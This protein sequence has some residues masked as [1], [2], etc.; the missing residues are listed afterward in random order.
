MTVQIL[1]RWIW[2][3]KWSSLVCTVFLLVICVTGLPLVFSDEIEGL[4]SDEL[5]LSAVPA[6]TPKG[7]LDQF[8]TIARRRYPGERIVWMGFD[9]DGAPKVKVV[10][11]PSWQV[12]SAD[13]SSAHALTLDA[14]TGK[15]LQDKKPQ[16]QTGP[17]VMNVILRLH[18]D[19]FAGLPGQL[20]LGG[21]AVLFI[22]AIASG[23][24]LYAPFMRKAEFGTIRVGKGARLKYLDY[25]NLAG[26]VLL[27]WMTVVGLT[28]FI[29]ELATPLFALWQ[30]TDVQA[31][32]T[33]YEGQSVPSE[34]ELT[35]PQAAYDMALAAVPGMKGYTIVFPG[36]PFG[37][38]YHYLVWTKGDNPLTARL[39]SPVLV[40]ARTGRLAGT[41]KMPWYLR[42]MQVSRPLHF[43]DY[44]GLPLKI[45][46]MLLDILAIAVLLTGVYLWVTRGRLTRQL[47]RST[48]GRLDE[49][50]L[51]PA[52]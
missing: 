46:W 44:G 2:L 45:I 13:R 12:F 39:F 42:A 34:T 33:V 16:S 17:G 32:L 49:A 22:I 21:M 43:G 5:P 27:A 24:V 14:R 1:R 37:T 29:N 19:L 40:D 11:T 9:D 51:G 7:S 20:F 50:T 8:A 28:G 31:M 10:M 35:S 52:E 4:V 38:P 15:V 6:T 30:K 25:H 36:A 41:L 23:V 47:H 26:I 48:E 18:E 3:H